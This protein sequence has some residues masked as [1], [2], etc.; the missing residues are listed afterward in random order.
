MPSNSKRPRDEAE[1]SIE[2]ADVEEV[3]LDFVPAP[4]ADAGENAPVVLVVDDDPEI[5]TLVARALGH[6]HTIYEAGDG[7]EALA[8]LEAIP[9]PDAIVCDVMMPRLDG[10][11]FAKAARNNPVLKRVPILFLTASTGPLDVIA[12]INAGGRH[13]V[14]KPFKVADLVAKVTGMTQRTKR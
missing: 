11:G 14:A 2:D 10:L 13:Y 12:G 7:Q 1:G 9:T 6:T 4:S 8:V 3:E 5:R